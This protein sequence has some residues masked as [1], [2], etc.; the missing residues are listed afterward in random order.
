MHLN[1][2]LPPACEI[3]ALHLFHETPAR[4]MDCIKDVSIGQHAA[5]LACKTGRHCLQNP[6]HGYNGGSVTT[7][8]EIGVE[9]D[10][11]DEKRS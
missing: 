5:G 1:L 11:S 8:S 9:I 7:F 2:Y 3:Q 10:V 6:H 4:I